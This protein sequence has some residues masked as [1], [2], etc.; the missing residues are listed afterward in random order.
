[1]FKLNHIV[2]IVDF[3]QSQH[4]ALPRA[5]ELAHLFSCKITVLANTYESFM[6]FIPSSSAIDRR[7]IKQEAIEQNQDKLKAMVAE[8]DAA[9]I[10]ISYQTVWNKSFHVG[11]IEFINQ[12]DFDLVV[13][14]A[15]AHS[16]LQKL[17]FTPTDWHLLRETKTNNLFVKKGSWP[18]KSSILGAINIEDDEQHRELNKK[19][20]VTTVKLAEVCQAKANILNVFPWPMIKLDKFNHLFD[21]KGL[22]LDIKQQH[23]KA[24]NSFVE[25]VAKIS[26]KVIVAEG[27]EPEETIPEMVK[28]SYSDLLVMGTVGRKGVQAAVIGNTAE[29]ILDE[30][31]CEV[32]AVK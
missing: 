29:K 12:N 31:E 16:N 15:R 8:L 18:S 11:L 26:G 22:F 13:K 10:D 30:I 23:S 28:S 27:L 24:V 3:R 20:I 4:F 14:T 21:K 17:L 9:D 5:V 25:S 2:A 6:E 1:M 19:I 32:L 7:L